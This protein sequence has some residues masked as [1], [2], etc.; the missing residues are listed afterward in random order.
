ML[1]AV[2]PTPVTMA[3]RPWGREEQLVLASGKYLLKRL[4][5]RK[6]CKGG[7]QYHRLKDECGYILSGKLRLVLDDGSGSLSSYIMGPGEFFHFPPGL[8]HQEEALEDCIILE[9]T[10]PHANDRV[11][12]E[13]KYG[14]MVDGEGLPTTTLEDVKHL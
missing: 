13:D 6:G 5:I 4:T 2:F 11:R 12:V 7:L 8:V 10:T 14:N 3:V 9:V 1:E